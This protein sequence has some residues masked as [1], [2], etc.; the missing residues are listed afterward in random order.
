MQCILPPRAPG[1]TFAKHRHTDL[2]TLRATFVA[3]G[4]IYA[5]RAGDAA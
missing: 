5:L 4:R 1:S 3:I 2:T